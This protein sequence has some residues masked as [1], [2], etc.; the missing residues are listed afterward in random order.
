M[1]RLGH[2]PKLPAGQNNKNLF[3]NL[4]PEALTR[5]PASFLSLS[6]GLL[7]HTGGSAAR[8]PA[9]LP[10]SWQRCRDLGH[11]THGT[12]LWPEKQANRAAS[13]TQ[14]FLSSHFPAAMDGWGEKTETSRASVLRTGVYGAVES[15]WKILL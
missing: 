4:S 13:W 8:Q 6:S 15:F 14:L 10:A 12:A 7:H 3:L 5:P 9:C 2:L 1:Q 11:S